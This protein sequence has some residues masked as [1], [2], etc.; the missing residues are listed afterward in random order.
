MIGRLEG[1]KTEQAYSIKLFHR[2][3]I[4]RSY[5]KCT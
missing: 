2:C 5:N 1:F 3:L 4:S